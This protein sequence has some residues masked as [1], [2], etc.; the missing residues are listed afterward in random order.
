MYHALTLNTCQQN[1]LIFGF[2]PFMGFVYKKKNLEYVQ[3]AKE[4]ET[5]Q[6]IT[7]DDYI[8]FS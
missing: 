4:E 6:N 7:N 1:Q 5:F 3:T 2:D 8:S